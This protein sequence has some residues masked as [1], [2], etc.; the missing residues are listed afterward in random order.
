MQITFI[1]WP[2]FWATIAAVIVAM[3]IYFGFVRPKL[4]P[5]PEF[6]DAFER[7]DKWFTAALAWLKVRW[8]MTLGVVIT[9]APIAW[10]GALDAIVALSLF[11]DQAAPALQGADLSWLVLPAWLKGVFQIAGPAL[12]IV[13][14]YILKTRGE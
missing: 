7:H 4:A 10:N 6:H 14:G 11:L 12:P 1:S 8:D 3:C 9:M 13:R 5:R 2:T